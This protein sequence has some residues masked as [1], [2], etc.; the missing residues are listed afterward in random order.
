[1]SR[2]ERPMLR[3]VEVIPGAD[4]DAEQITL[5]DPSG[6][7]RGAVT[8]SPAAL[9]LVSRFDGEHTLEDIQEAFLR[10]VGQAVDRETLERLVDVL[11]EVRLLAGP[12]F[13]AYYRELEAAY[14]AS[15]VRAHH[16]PVAVGDP[17]RPLGEYF[18]D[19]L[20]EERP[21][22]V[23]AGPPAGLVAPHLDYPRGRP[24]YGAS[25]A[26]LRE[27]GAGVRRFVVLGTNHF[28][29]ARGVVGTARDFDTPFGVLRADAE[30]MA[31]LQERLGRP[32]TQHEFDHA[33]EH[34]VELQA[35]WIRYLYREQPEVS[36]VPL[37]CPDPCGPD[38]ERA[39]ADLRAIGEAL[40]D[41]LRSDPVPTCIV[42]GADLSHVGGRF[43][44]DRWLDEAF[45][46]E[47]AARDRRVLEVLEAN[48]A[49][50]FR[51]AVAEGGNPTRICSAGCLYAL[52]AALPDARA[53]VLRYHQA[54]HQATQTAVTCA[55]AMFVAPA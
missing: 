7:A 35:A 12:G 20:D 41:L 15:P 48:D 46:G 3:P 44:D 9:W 37:L 28:G 24:C 10:E 23:P 21:A 27:R 52:M 47:V 22:T 39:L 18:R 25:Y 26:L 54:V 42:A 19:I 40:R 55:S 32:L 2:P 50:G 30:F 53:T 43:G 16:L 45:L 36:L 8:L 29:R 11:D 38:G 5:V 33:R 4:G 17:P 14:R 49:E 34:S 31:A 1:M 51:Q 13:D 6:L